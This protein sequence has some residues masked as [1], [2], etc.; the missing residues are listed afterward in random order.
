VNRPFVV[1]IRENHSG[2]ILFIGT[3]MDPTA[4]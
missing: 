1:V 3:V 4:G 2:T